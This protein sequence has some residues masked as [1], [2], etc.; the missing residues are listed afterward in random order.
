MDLLNSEIPKIEDLAYTKDC[1]IP[2][3]EYLD[4]YNNIK[5]S[6]YHYSNRYFEQIIL[7]ISSQS[8]ATMLDIL[9]Q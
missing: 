9:P 2:I 1:N 4:K 5:K 8:N 3:K 6:F 7:Q